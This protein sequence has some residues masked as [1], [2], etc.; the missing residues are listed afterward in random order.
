MLQRQA[1]SAVCAQAAVDPGMTSSSGTPK[2][3]FALTRG[4]NTRQI[5]HANDA[6][7]DT[8]VMGATEDL[9]W[10]GADGAKVQGHLIKP[11]NFDPSKKYPAIVLIHGG[12]QGAWSDSWSYRWNP[13]PF[14]ARGYVILM[15]NPRGSSGFGQKFGRQ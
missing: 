4:G 3:V 10:E 5:T 9:W 7:L 13:Q 12:P 14:A 11:P 15:P 1:S 8:L 6:L 2:P